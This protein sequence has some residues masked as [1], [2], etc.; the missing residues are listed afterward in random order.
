MALFR[1]PSSRA[2][3]PP[4]AAHDCHR[5]PDWQLS[6]VMKYLLLALLASVNIA[7]AFSAENA[8]YADQIQKWRATR[9]KNS[10]PPTVG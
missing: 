2:P 3:H 10:A 9:K 1:L 8:P 5:R 6:C 7:T 4:P